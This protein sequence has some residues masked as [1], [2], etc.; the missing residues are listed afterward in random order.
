MAQAYEEFCSQSSDPQAELLNYCTAETIQRISSL[1]ES[2]ATRHL[3]FHI[4]ELVDSVSNGVLRTAYWSEQDD[5]IPIVFDS[6][7]SIS[8]SPVKKDFVALDVGGSHN[9]SGLTGTTQ[10]EGVGTVEWT[11]MDDRGRPQKIVTQ[12]YNV[13]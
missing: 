9:L 2:T 1:F 3:A 4:N 11:V 5:P 10:V 12:A 6:G 8:V 7:A 13:P